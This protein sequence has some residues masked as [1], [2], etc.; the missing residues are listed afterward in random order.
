VRESLKDPYRF[1]FLS[2]TVDA[3]ERD[4]E[5]ALIKHVTDFLL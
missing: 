3:Q 5:S 1:E 2:L 4:I